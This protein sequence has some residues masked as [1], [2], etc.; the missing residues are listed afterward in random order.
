MKPLHWTLVSAA[1]SLAIGSY[2]YGLEVAVLLLLGF[3]L[4]EIGHILAL[5]R[6]GA[7]VAGVYF[8]PLLGAFLDTDANLRLA[9]DR[10]VVALAGPAAG[11]VSVA[12]GLIAWRV[13]GDDRIE[14]AAIVLARVNI[15]NILPALPLDGGWA[16]EACLAGT[17]SR[18]RMTLLA[19]ALFA[20]VWLIESEGY[21]LFSAA[22]FVLGA[23]QLVIRLA[24]ET[25][26]VR[27]MS[28]HEVLGA[29]GQY[30]AVA[31]L[32]LG[33]AT[34]WGGEP[35]T[36]PNFPAVTDEP[37]REVSHTCRVIGSNPDGTPIED[38]EDCLVIMKGHGRYS[39]K[40]YGQVL[41][42]DC[43]AMPTLDHASGDLDDASIRCNHGMGMVTL[44]QVG[45]QHTIGPVDVVRE[46]VDAGPG[47]FLTSPD[48]HH[49]SYV[50]HRGTGWYLVVDGIDHR[51]KGPVT[52]LLSYE[53]D[54]LGGQMYV[55][56][57]TGNQVI[58]VVLPTA[59]SIVI[60]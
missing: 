5:R 1:A 49:V 3:A 24:P 47:M 8:I 14:V 11:F 53:Y 38:P 15:L 9:R 17:T 34:A 27:A 23:F 31:F 22:L 21:E 59:S 46:A 55:E 37:E 51:L 54:P 56:Y 13:T 30:A 16:L 18:R 48:G 39:V 57:V 26:K 6:Y 29:A 4:H 20:S 33:S 40:R 44:T 42:D 43:V 45:T 10:F 2:V 35:E 28:A 50:A 58:E 52:A 41:M 36:C 19:F 60:R 7:P 32:L 25:P 12:L